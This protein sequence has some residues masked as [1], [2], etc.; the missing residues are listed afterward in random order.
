MFPKMLL[1]EFI[2]LT[3][4]E[5]SAWV[6]VSELAEMEMHI[7]ENSSLAKATFASFAS[8]VSSRVF[9]GTFGDGE[10]GD[11]LANQNHVKEGPQ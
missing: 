2:S 3:S 7:L 11:D 6:F 5:H 10:G 4:L 8:Y 1:P 9:Q